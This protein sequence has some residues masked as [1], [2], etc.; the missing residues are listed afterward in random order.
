MGAVDQPWPYP[1]SGQLCGEGQAGGSSADDEDVD[2]I[3]AH[4]LTVEVR[5]ALGLMN[6]CHPP[7]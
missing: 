2:R 4:D 1:V 5:N 7:R 6:E 3:V